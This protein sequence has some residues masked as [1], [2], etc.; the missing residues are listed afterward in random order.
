MSSVQVDIGKSGSSGTDPSLSVV[1]VVG[2]R[3]DDTESAYRS[4]RTAL[5]LI[6]A[7]PEFIYVLAG[8]N[9]LVMDALLALRARGEHIAII[10]LPEQ[11]SEAACLREGVARAK[12]SNI[13][14]LPPY[15]Q[16]APDSLPKLV[17]G[18]ESADFVVAKRD[19][20]GDSTFNR[21]RGF[22]FRMLG[23][24]AG[25]RFDDLGC[26]A[27]ALRREV[28]DEVL[29]QDG[30]HTFLPLF[31]E[32][33]G[34]VVT[35][36]LLPQAATDRKLRSHRPTVYLDHVLDIVAI[37]FL[38]KFTQKPFRFFG[39]IGMISVAFGVMIGIELV[40]DRFVFN[41]PMNERPMLVLAVLLVVLGIQIAAVGLIAEIIIFTR[42]NV[43]STY[44][45]R[46]IV[47]RRAGDVAV[48]EVGERSAPPMVPA[49][50]AS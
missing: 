1:I 27:R 9:Q 50:E 42:T 41:V 17:A 26:I 39:S 32:R 18:L 10:S 24:I 40:F 21:L 47:D 11:F 49:S 44:R 2:S 6:C 22:G 31:V 37:A 45:I 25:S 5:S 8:R 7:S 16:V 38:L 23:R 4:Y 15:L 46:E 12:G 33:A 35:E 48:S 43:R 28:F 19:R 34:F 29:L 30:H 13:L 20:R 3:F 14:I 36:V